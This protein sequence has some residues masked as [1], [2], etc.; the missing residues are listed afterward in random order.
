MRGGRGLLII[1]VLA[2]TGVAVAQ[3]PPPLTV[4]VERV[5]AGAPPGTRFG[6][7]VVDPDGREIVAINAGQRFI[8]ASNTKIV[9]TAA[10][11]ATLPAIDRADQAA[12]TRVRL[13][14]RAGG[15]SDVV[16]EGR[17]DPFLSG[18]PDCTRA[19]L[20]ELA[21][22]VAA[23]ARIVG[24]VVGDASYFPDE[25]W[26]PGMSWN[27]IP[28]RSG[29]G[30]AALGI[31][32]HETALS[33]TPGGSGQP[34]AIGGSGYFTIDN[35][36]VTVSG[37]QV[38]L[39]YD[40]APNRR[41]L[42]ITGTIGSA[43]APETL[44]VGVD[45]PAHYAAWRLAEML[46]AR[47][48]RITG[49]IVSRYRPADAG[50]DPARR[51]NAPPPRAPDQPAIAVTALPPLTEDATTINKVSQNVHA[52][53]MLRRVGRVAGT[54]SIADGQA[55]V[56]A[57]LARASVAADAIALSDGSGMSTYNRM[58]P[59]GT[60]ALLRWIEGQSW[61]ATWRATLPVGGVDGTLA[62]RFKG[63]PL[64]G[65]VFAKT[66]SLN[67]T[68]AL[69]GYLVARSGRM[70]T[71]A[72]FANDVPAGGSATPAMDAALVAIAEAN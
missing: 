53:L 70:L 2:M 39:S 15:I 34:P 68:S 16:L 62:R 32:D 6:L 37:D 13:S 69:S 55:A 10:A 38:D 51:G 18:A 17:G 8:P 12:G 33:V 64:E 27:N 31:D 7:L 47:G 20:S 49:E 23:R 22:A 52:E 59:R 29:T 40:R 72:L 56:R 63:T 14:P 66:G 50:D 65:R 57:M 5:F 54:G 61:G 58:T 24:D 28:T 60:V 71:F 19:C 25:R 67:A 11:F 30:I 44:R 21:D 43:A 1:G 9:T 48:V 4:Q 42:R 35:R 46:K 45:D 3:D 36:A 26:P 41:V